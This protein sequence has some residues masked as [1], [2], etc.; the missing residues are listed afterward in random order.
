MHLMKCHKTIIVFF[1]PHQVSF[2]KDNSLY[3]LF[4]VFRSMKSQGLLIKQ[5]SCI[6]FKC[7]TYFR[8]PRQNTQHA[9]GNRWDIRNSCPEILGISNKQLISITLVKGRQSNRNVIYISTHYVPHMPFAFNPFHAWSNKF[10]SNY[11]PC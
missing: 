8:V 6:Y 3:P 11:L 7:S 9:K 10:R 5:I 2:S 1:L 4:T